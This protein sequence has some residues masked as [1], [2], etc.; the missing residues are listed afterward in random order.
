MSPHVLPASLTELLRRSTSAGLAFS[1]LILILYGEAAAEIYT[2]NGVYQSSPCSPD[3]QKAVP[4]FSK[5]ESS[6]SENQTE[7]STRSTRASLFHELT[8]RAIAAKQEFGLKLDISAEEKAC[9]APDA[10]LEHCTTAVR[11]A[12]RELDSRLTTFR[13][14]KNQEEANRLQEEANRREEERSMNNATTIV[15]ID[16]NSDYLYRRRHHYHDGRPGNW[17]GGGSW[18]GGHGSGWDISADFSGTSKYDD[19][20]F[21]IRG[22]ELSVTGGARPLPLDPR[23]G[24]PRFD[25]HDRHDSH[26][27]RPRSGPGSAGG[28]MISVPR[29]SSSNSSHGRNRS[30]RSGSRDDGASFGAVSR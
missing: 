5:V 23:D 3:A 19:S 26:H 20:N 17:N 9:T 12:E 29:P 28:S 22:Q 27:R 24:A 21:S 6:G 25:D 15:N 11:D 30:G 7:P 13:S 4:A 14:A 1:A 16:D 18:N 8:M 2:C 10:T